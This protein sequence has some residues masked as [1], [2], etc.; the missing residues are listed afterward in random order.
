[1]KINT[2]NIH[3]FKM[4]SKDMYWVW[5]VNTKQSFWVDKTTGEIREISTIVLDDV[6]N[7]FFR[8]VEIPIP[9]SWKPSIPKLVKT[10]NLTLHFRGL[11]IENITD[12]ELNHLRDLLNKYSNE[13]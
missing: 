11:K 12:E 7:S 2:D 10:T 8:G 1:M 3:V 6:L 5:D 9:E 13:D 4:H